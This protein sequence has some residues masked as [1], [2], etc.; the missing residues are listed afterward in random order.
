M[1][2]MC[3][4][5]LT[6]CAICV[7]SSAHAVDANSLVG[8]VLSGNASKAPLTETE[9]KA[10]PAACITIGMGRIDGMFWAEGMKKN[11]TEALLDLPENAMAKNA[12]WFHHF[13]WGRLSK[14][15]SIY[16][17]TEIKRKSE[18]KMWRNNMDFI[19]EW[20]AKQKLN[21]TYMPTVYTELAESFLVEKNY[22][23]AIT[24]AEKSLRINPA[25]PDA[26]WILSDSYMAVGNKKKA[27]DVTTEGLKYAPESK[28]L[29]RR[30]KELGGQ[31]PYPEPYPTNVANDTG[32]SEKD[33]AAA[34]A[35]AIEQ[36]PSTPEKPAATP[37]TT[38]GPEATPKAQDNIGQPGK[39]NPHCRF[40]P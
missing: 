40:C 22:A 37:A 21:W 27:M 12:S 5:L 36:P 7:I 13:C 10:M 3:A 6:L 11:K 31:P 14:L 29:K 34:S 20:T 4:K 9:I 30:Y 16:A 23:K 19:V 33:K 2:N 18:I 38:S 28:G 25:H 1:K 39:A 24:E 17:K 32:V 15:R 26:Y 35:P 8:T